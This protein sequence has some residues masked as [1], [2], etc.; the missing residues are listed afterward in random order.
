MSK[1][2]ARTDTAAPEFIDLPLIGGQADV[3]ESRERLRRRRLITLI[4]WCTPIAAFLWWRIFRDNA[5]NIFQVPHIDWLVMAPVI[6][7]LV[8]ILL[9]GGQFAFSGRSPHVVASKRRGVV[10][11]RVRANKRR[12]ASSRRAAARL[13]SNA[14]GKGVAVKKAKKA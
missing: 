2:Q 11:K 1:T 6:F 12:V 13:A 4:S 5:I 10:K 3:G 7:F 9:I 14:R 8:L